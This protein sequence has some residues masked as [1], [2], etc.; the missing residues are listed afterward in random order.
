MCR[1]ESSVVCRCYPFIT[2]S[3][4]AL[5]ARE[6]RFVCA[7]ASNNTDQTFLFFV[8]YTTFTI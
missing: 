6:L 4:K 1:T 7:V 2:F 5:Y 3:G 8:S